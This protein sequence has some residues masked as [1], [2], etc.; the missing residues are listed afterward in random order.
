MRKTHLLYAAICVVATLLAPAR[1]DEAD[2]KAPPLYTVTRGGRQAKAILLIT[3]N[4]HTFEVKPGMVQFLISQTDLSSGENDGKVRMFFNPLPGGRPGSVIGYLEVAGSGKVTDELLKTI[5]NRL[6]KI[7]LKLADASATTYYAAL[8]SAEEEANMAQRDVEELSHQAQEHR[9]RLL[10]DGIMPKKLG[11]QIA[12]ID[13]ERFSLQVELAGLEARHN[14]LLPLIDKTGDKIEIA[15]DKA[16][17]SLQPLKGVTELRANELKRA[18]ELLKTARASR[19]ELDDAEVKL[20]MAQAEL[21]ER[22]R[23]IAEDC[24]RGLLESLSEQAV[25]VEIERKS[26]EARLDVIQN[27]I[28]LFQDGMIFDLIGNYRDITRRLA[29]TQR[30]RDDA[31]DELAKLKSQESR[32]RSPRVQIL[33]LDKLLKQKK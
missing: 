27:R 24:D 12:K 18:R 5:E 2:K 33:R 19:R 16:F 26:I 17:E 29:E 3:S 14:T 20:Y 23:T 13:R 6:Q 1:A 31:V 11:E 8:D 22:R 9:N 25:E 28:E 30:R 7:F 15:K 32:M 21:A 4:P 10:R